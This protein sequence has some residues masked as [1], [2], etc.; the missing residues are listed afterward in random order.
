MILIVKHK[1]GSFQ[2]QKSVQLRLTLRFIVDKLLYLLFKKKVRVKVYFDEKSVYN[3][4]NT[5]QLDW[6]KIYGT[7]SGITTFTNNES[8]LV[9]RCISPLEKTFQVAR[10]IRTANKGFEV[11]NVQTQKLTDKEIMF[12]EYVELKQWLPVT[13]WAGGDEMNKSNYEYKI[14][15]K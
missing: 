1:A 15:L 8:I 9:Y 3:M 5:N 11:E 2:E 10:Y 6:R 14:K 13:P 7:K 4:G 12:E